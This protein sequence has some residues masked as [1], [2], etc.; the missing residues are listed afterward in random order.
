MDPRSLFGEALNQDYQLTGDKRFR[1]RIPMVCLIDNKPIYD[2]Q[3]GD[4]RIVVKSKRE[5]IDMLIVR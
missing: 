3:A 4:G 2:H 1:E 5:A